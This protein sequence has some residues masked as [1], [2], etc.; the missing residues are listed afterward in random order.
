MPRVQIPDWRFEPEPVWVS[1]QSIREADWLKPLDEVL[2]RFNSDGE[3]FVA[4]VPER[5][6]DHS[7]SSI[8]GAIIADVE[9]GVLVDIPVETLT[10]GNRIMVRDSE[11]ESVLSPRQPGAS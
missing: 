10:S 7:R 3:Q 11:R 8:W 4:F 9:G 2:V 1:C 5:Y 6:I